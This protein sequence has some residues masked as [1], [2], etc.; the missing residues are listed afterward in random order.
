MKNKEQGG[1]QY[2]AHEFLFQKGVFQV[3]RYSGDPIVGYRRNIATTP[4]P[5]GLKRND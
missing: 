1:V 5:S 2:Y 4:T 3:G